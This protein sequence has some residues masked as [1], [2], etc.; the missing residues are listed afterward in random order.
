MWKNTHDIEQQRLTKANTRNTRLPVFVAMDQQTQSIIDH[1]HR[2]R[3]DALRNLY[4]NRSEI[5]MNIR[6]QRLFRI[7]NR[8]HEI[9]IRAPAQHICCRRKLK[10]N[11][12]EKTLNT[13]RRRFAGRAVDFAGR[14]VCLHLNGGN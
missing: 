8:V 13:N 9:R 2:E 5:H 1:R 12:T 14:I 11:R 4:E 6:D 10:I 7:T 3:G